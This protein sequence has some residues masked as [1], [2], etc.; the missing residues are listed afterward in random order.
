MTETGVAVSDLRESKRALR[1][2]TQLQQ[3]EVVSER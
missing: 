1:G 2:G 3:A